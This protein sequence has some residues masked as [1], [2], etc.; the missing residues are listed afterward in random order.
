MSYYYPR[1]EDSR[2]YIGAIRR[3]V[4]DKNDYPFACSLVALDIACLLRVDGYNPRI[5]SL[6]GE[7]IDSV[8]TAP[9]IPR[10]L[11]PQLRWGAHLVCE[12]GG[13]T[14]DPLVSEQP[15]VTTSYLEDAFVQPAR[16]SEIIQGVELG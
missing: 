5:L 13:F 14:Y 10:H 1:L 7:K 3:E 2:S 12:L 15:Q 11:T 4:L 16:I 9:L 6:T 8:N